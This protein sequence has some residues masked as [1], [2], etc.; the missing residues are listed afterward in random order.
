[1]KN[2]IYVY[3]DKKFLQIQFG[4]IDYC[5][6]WEVCQLNCCFLCIIHDSVHASSQMDKM[7]KIED[8]LQA[9]IIRIIREKCS[10][11]Y[12]FNTSYLR[13]GLF[14]CH[15]NPTKA[16]YRSTL[17]NPFPTVN[18][19]YLVG[20]IQRWVSTSPSMIVNGL[21]VRVSANCI[22]CVDNLD[23]PECVMEVEDDSEMSA[24]I[25]RIFN[26][27]AVRELGEEICTI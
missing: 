20:I 1:M 23:V 15:Q 6:N 3:A 19:T 18:A 27:C 21:L 11:C 2:I 10:D 9:I 12:N 24:R 8:Q 7:K 14:L 16:T 17:V 5:L 4:P 22:T 25:S 13:E 26:V